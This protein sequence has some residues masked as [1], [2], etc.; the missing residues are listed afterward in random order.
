MQQAVKDNEPGCIFYLLFKSRND[1]TAYFVM[2]Q[3][4]DADAL[5]QHGQSDAFKAGGVKLG[6]A[7]GGSAPQPAPSA[8]PVA[9]PRSSTMEQTPPV[10]SA[11][12]RRLFHAS[13]EI[14]LMDLVE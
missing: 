7:F 12:R 2:E 3:Y 10:A 6:P 8:S 13:T 5:R 11:P 4:E 9:R 1:P 14:E